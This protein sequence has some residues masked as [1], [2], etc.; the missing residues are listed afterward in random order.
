M[1]DLAK[2]GEVKNLTAFNEYAEEQ[3]NKLLR[4]GWEVIAVKI[5]EEQSMYDSGSPT[6]HIRKEG[7]AHYILGK[8]R[9]PKP[10]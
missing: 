1:A 6:Q 7:Q 2:Y 9:K 8:P 4:E 5:V 3:I 10:A